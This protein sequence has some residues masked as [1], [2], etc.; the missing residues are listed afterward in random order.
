MSAV[1]RLE[2]RSD[3]TPRHDLPADTP[4]VETA[5]AIEEVLT[6]LPDKRGAR[7][8]PLLA[9][10]PYMARYR[11]R[12]TLASAAVGSGSAGPG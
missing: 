11:G 4:S 1:E 7:L 9:L 3:G 6:V 8:R 10:A 5:S 2:D 12:A